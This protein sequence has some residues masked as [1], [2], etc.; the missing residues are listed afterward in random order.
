MWVFLTLRETL[1]ISNS[2]NDSYHE[3]PCLLEGTQEV[4]S[5][6]TVSASSLSFVSHDLY[7]LMTF[8]ISCLLSRI[9]A[10]V[11]FSLLFQGYLSS[12]FSITAHHT[13]THTHVYACVWEREREHARMHA[14]TH[15][16]TLPR[17]SMFPEVSN[18]NL[19]RRYLRSNLNPSSSYLSNW[20]ATD[21][22]IDFEYFKKEI[23]RL[24]CN[25]A[26]HKS[27]LYGTYVGIFA[28]SYSVI[29][30]TPLNEFLYSVTVTFVI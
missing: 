5:S 24:C 18:I 30:E 15:A 25:L 10:A 9:S 14:R 1:F 26:T 12:G 21:V 19:P 20:L 7:P 16:T 27:E 6:N 17:L 13:H 22:C 8:R 23:P 2:V 11:A 28:C 29:S 3:F 4:H